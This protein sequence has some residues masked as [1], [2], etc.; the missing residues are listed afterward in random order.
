MK[1]AI[2]LLPILLLFSCGRVVEGT[3]DALNKGGELAGSAATE[4][5]EGVTTGVED[6][7]SIDVALSEELKAKGLTIGKTQVESDSADMDNMLIVYVV[8][9]QAFNGA[10]NAVA[11]DEE[12]REMGRSQLI[13]E[14]PA[15]GA[16]Y[17]TFHFQSRTD[18][19]RKSRVVLR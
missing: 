3:K 11:S 5:I 19:E 16:D 15:G 12:G 9:D 17:F 1:K 8:A 18:L 2:Q 10:V 14:L 13:M 4:V 6:T 7:W